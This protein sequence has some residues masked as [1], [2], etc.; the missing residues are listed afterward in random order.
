MRTTRS[1]WSSGISSWNPG[2]SITSTPVR[3]LREVGG[4]VSTEAGDLA[5]V[6]AS[7]CRWRRG[8]APA[9]GSCRTCGAGRCRGSTTTISVIATITMR[10]G[11]LNSGGARRRTGRGGVASSAPRLLR[12][13]AASVVATAST[14]PAVH[15]GCRGSARER[16]GT[17]TPMAISRR[18]RPHRPRARRPLPPARPDRCRRER[19]RLRRRRRPPPR[20]VAVKVLHVAL[21]EDAGF[22]RR[23]RAEAQ[24]AASLHHPNVMAVYDWGEDDVPFMV[25][26]LLDRRQPAR[27]AR[28]AAAGLSPSQA[29]HVGRQVAQRAR[30][31]PRRGGSCTATSSPPTSCSTST[32]SS[33]SPTS[34]SRARSPRRAGPSRRARSSAPRGTPRPSRRPA[35]RSTAAPTSTRSRSCSSRRSPARCPTSATR[36][37]ATL[38]GA[39][40]RRRLVAPAELGRLGAGASSAPG[41]PSPAER[42][43]DAATMARRS[44]TPPASC[45][46]RNRSSSPASATDSTTPNRRVSASRCPRRPSGVAGGGAGADPAADAT[47]TDDAVP[48]EVFDFEQP[49]ARS[50]RPRTVVPGTSRPCPTSVGAAIILAVIIGV[51]ALAGAGGFGGGGGPVGRPEPGRPG[52]EGRRGAATAAGVLMKIVPRTAD[53]PATLVISQDPGPGDFVQDGDDACNSSW[54]SS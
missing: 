53:D 50:R 5:R 17:V 49:A 14:V 25:L 32:A 13:R 36:R 2:P 22:L 4:D 27:H 43:P 47:I 7:A 11:C 42:Y 23:F 18:R 35:R 40:A 48:V 20:R 44:P 24:L 30:V 41:K 15:P 3:S 6:R 51:A 33:A 38:G 16:P 37:S 29:A 1:S 19:P 46:R 26:E 45:R 9:D 54:S 21:A 28:R 39:H 10:H 34:A 8:T 52:P 12:S 31:R